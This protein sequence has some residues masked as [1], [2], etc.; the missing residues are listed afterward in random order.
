MKDKTDSFAAGVACGAAGVLLALWVDWCNHPP[1]KRP[2]HR[3]K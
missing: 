1:K 3:I 2:R